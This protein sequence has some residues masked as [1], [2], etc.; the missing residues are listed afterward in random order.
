MI[1]NANFSV[2]YALMIHVIHRELKTHPSS[3][4]VNLLRGFIVIIVFD[5]YL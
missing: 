2:Q 5:K 4:I 1:I 3:P